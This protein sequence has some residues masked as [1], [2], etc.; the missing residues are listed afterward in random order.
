MEDAHTRGC[1][2]SHSAIHDV[3]E[4]AGEGRTTPWPRRQS[5]ARG[6]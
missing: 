3:D 1:L 5:D 4:V 6:S 2:E